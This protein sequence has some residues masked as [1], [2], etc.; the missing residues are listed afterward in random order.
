MASPLLKTHKEP[1]LPVV[2]LNAAGVDI[3]SRFH[4]VAVAADRDAEP[5][6]TF[7]TFTAELQQA[8]YWLQTVGI[9][10]VAMESTSVYWVPVYEI[11]TARGFEV[12]LTPGVSPVPPPHADPTD[13]GVSFHW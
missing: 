5:V 8:A 11:L 10:T 6:R 3:G 1:D 12:L 2:H 4:A 13:T 9:T 7:G